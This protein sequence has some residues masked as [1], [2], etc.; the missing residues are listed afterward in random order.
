MI[1]F[2]PLPSPIDGISAL[3]GVIGLQLAPVYGRM[4][5]GER[6]EIESV[7]GLS[8][9]P[10]FGIDDQ[11]VGLKIQLVGVISHEVIDAPGTIIGSE[12]DNLVGR[13]AAI[14]I[15]TRAGQSF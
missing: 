5:N 14:A 4:P 11:G 7:K 1:P 13:L 10:I 8:G 15:R 12:I 6:A 2:D 3:P 9:S